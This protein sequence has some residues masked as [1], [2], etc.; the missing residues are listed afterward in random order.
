MK[1]TNFVKR[2]FVSTLAATTLFACSLYSLAQAQSSGDWQ[3]LFNGEDLTGW[4]PKIRGHDLGEDPY[5][6]F[7][8]EDGLLSVGYEGYDAFNN[9]F[10]HLFYERPCGSYELRVEYRFI[11]EQA[12]GGA[13][14]ALRNSGVMFHSQNPQSM[15]REQDFP[16]SI[17]A[18]LLGGNGSDPRPTLNLC[19][20]GTHVTME[21]R[22]TEQH[23]VNSSSQTYH[24][25][26]WVTV[27]LI[28]HGQ[29]EI[30][31]VIDGQTVL[32]YSQPVV[33]GGMVNGHEASAKE[34][35]KRLASGYIA[36]QSESHPVQFRQV[37]IREL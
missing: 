20:P 37:L 27:D 8:V 23:C 29:G 16:I 35:G 13:G 2:V 33:G 21:G 30:E 7:R 17:E 9:R 15:G 19:T 5:R 4:T 18:Q 6:T 31:H 22:L 28:V 10:G 3:P 14:W 12:S 11:G 32:R 34:D 1:K 25:D 36:L 26:G 24:G